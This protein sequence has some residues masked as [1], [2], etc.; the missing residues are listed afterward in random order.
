MENYDS[1]NKSELSEVF[2]FMR[3]TLKNSMGEGNP[4]I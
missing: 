4:S 1:D 2:S 3:S